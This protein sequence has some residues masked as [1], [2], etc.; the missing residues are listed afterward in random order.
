MH[1]S[2]TIESDVTL[3]EK[4]TR[5]YNRNLGVRKGVK[6]EGAFVGVLSTTRRRLPKRFVRAGARNEAWWE[7]KSLP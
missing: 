7:S 6:L 1:F 2:F 3:L 4:V 5:V